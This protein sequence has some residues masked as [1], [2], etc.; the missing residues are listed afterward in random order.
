[1]VSLDLLSVGHHSV[2]KQYCRCR[3]NFEKPAQS[4]KTYIVVA[5]MIRFDDLS[6]FV[7][8]AATGSFSKAAREVDLPPAQVSTAIKRLEGELGIRLF[9]RSTRSLRL[10][11]EGQSYLPYAREVLATLHEGHECLRTD[12]S[13]LSGVLQVA[14]PSDLGRG[15]LLE[16]LTDFRV[17]NPGLELRLSLSDQICDLFKDPV[18]VAFRYGI[19]DDANFISM[20]IAPDNRRVMFASPG[21]L[22]LRGEPRSLEDLVD[23]DCLLYMMQ[24]RVYDKWE[25]PTSDGPKFLTV[26]GP[27]VCDNADVV[28]QWAIAGQGIGYKSWLDVSTDVHAGRLVVVMPDQL[29]KVWP[30]NLICPHRRQFSPAVQKL[31]AAVINHCEVLNA[32]YD[33]L[34]TQLMV[35]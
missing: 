30:L 15:V 26:S 20:P 10:T 23:H 18:D 3:H 7:R 19:I 11:A 16:L 24:G 8:S 32:R 2:V 31:Y 12:T 33:S 22:S 34:V 27:L 9:A 35:V 1:M 25:F 6:L 28:R 21:Y 17:Q 4:C 5:K 13:V 14:A 29:G